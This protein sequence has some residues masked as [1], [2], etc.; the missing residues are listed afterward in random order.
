MTGIYILK[1]NLS[2]GTVESRGRDWGGSWTGSPLHLLELLHLQLI[3]VEQILV[4]CL[5]T[6]RHLVFIRGSV[7]L[8]K[9][10]RN[11]NLNMESLKEL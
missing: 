7:Y 10:I 3:K 11:K 5:H 1:T 8:S 6:E 2:D 4:D 9:N